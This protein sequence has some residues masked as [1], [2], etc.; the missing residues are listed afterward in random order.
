MKEQLDF[1]VLVLFFLFFIFFLPQI[2]RTKEIL[3]VYSIITIIPLV[4]VIYDKIN[5]PLCNLI[6]TSKSD[7]S[8]IIG[9][10]MCKSSLVVLWLLLVATFGVIFN[11]GI[12]F[13]LNFKKYKIT[14]ISKALITV[15]CIWYSLMYYFLN[16]RFHR[17]IFKYL[18][19]SK[20][21]AIR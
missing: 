2:L 13:Y 19:N 12:I 5:D 1:I 4:I 7:K 18:L 6:I 3:I 16:P 15:I 8:E 14:I 10:G 21:I 20:K 11:R 9:S 17:N